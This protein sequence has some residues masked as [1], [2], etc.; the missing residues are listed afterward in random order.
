MMKTMIKLTMSLGLT[1][2]VAQQATAQQNR[3]CAPRDAV[4]ERLANT[5]GESR[6]SIGLG[7]Q[8]MVIET[9]ASSSTGTWTITV[10][11]PTGQTC[12][13]ASGRS[14]EELAE[15]LPPQGNDA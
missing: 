6:Q 8:G 12:L 5:Y 4:I 3:K 14:W 2:M 9:F 10:T 11:T 15:A 7:E 1:V 13:V